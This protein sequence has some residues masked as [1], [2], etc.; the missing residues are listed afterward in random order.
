MHVTRKLRAHAHS[1]TQ[2]HTLNLANRRA[3]IASVQILFIL[4]LDGLQIENNVSLAYTRTNKLIDK[5]MCRA[6]M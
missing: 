3:G 4:E 2:P 6:G 1:L 5:R